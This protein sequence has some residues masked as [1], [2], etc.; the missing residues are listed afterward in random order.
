MG[1]K[2]VSKQHLDGIWSK[3]SSSG[4][5][6]DKCRRRDLSPDQFGG[7]RVGSAVTEL[8][9]CIGVRY[10][11]GGAGP[12]AEVVRRSPYE[13]GADRDASQY[14][15]LVYAAVGSAAP[16]WF[17]VSSGGAEVDC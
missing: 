14:M 12:V 15:G 2:Q 4:R 3:G 1:I 17:S 7:R 16:V 5:F 11:F 8:K 10:S 9:H 6:G 13:F